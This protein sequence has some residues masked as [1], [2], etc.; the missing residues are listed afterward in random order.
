MYLYNTLSREK[1]LLCPQENQRISMYCCGPTVYNYAHIGNLRTYIFEDIIHRVLAV[2]G[3]GVTHVVNIT[4][5]GHLTSDGDDGEDKV[6]TAARQRGMSVSEIADMF[7]EAFL[8]DCHALNIIPADQYPRAT[9]YI[10]DIIQFISDLE[11]RGYTYIANGNLYFDTSKDSTYGAMRG[12]RDGDRAYA[13]VEADTGKKHP[14]DFVLWFTNSKFVD[15]AMHWSS[16]W[17]DGYPGWH[18]EC[19]AITHATLGERFD[20]HCGGIDHISV[21]HTNEMA[22]NYGRCGHVGAR[23][24]VHG[25][26]LIIGKDQKMSKSDSNFLTLSKLADDG[27]APLVYRYFVLQSHYRKPLTFHYEALTAAKQALNRLRI[28]CQGLLS[29]EAAKSERTQEWI[30]KGMQSVCDDFNTPETLA[31]VWQALKSNELNESEKRTI[32]MHFEQILALDLFTVDTPDNES[33]QDDEPWIDQKI[34]ERN[35]ARRNKDFQQADQIRQEL[36]SKGIILVD[37]ANGTTW[38]RED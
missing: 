26:F 15:H 17:G 10:D 31:T 33:H 22:Q 20:I 37:T 9:A 12:Y 23:Y 6:I 5:V 4:D 21:H 7:T 36:L 16:P 30:A 2:A 35:Q 27:F 25:E 14:N 32:V 1:E 3:Y 28:R 11:A 18:I 38:R 8:Q 29:V 19:S 34:R 24:W 13:R